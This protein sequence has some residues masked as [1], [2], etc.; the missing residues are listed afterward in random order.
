MQIRTSP[1]WE[2][3]EYPG[4]DYC[5]VSSTER[6]WQTAEDELVPVENSYLFVQA[7]QREKISYG[8]LQ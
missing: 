4:G 5:I 8:N 1:L 2:E 3:E 7:L 6:L